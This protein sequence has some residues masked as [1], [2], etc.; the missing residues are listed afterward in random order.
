MCPDGKAYSGAGLSRHSDQILP[1][2]LPDLVLPNNS[3]GSALL[4]ATE[5]G[6][7][8]GC[9]LL[10]IWGGLRR[11]EAKR[12]L[13]S[14]CAFKKRCVETSACGMLFGILTCGVKRP[15]AKSLASTCNNA[16]AKVPD[17][18]KLMRRCL[19]IHGG[20]TAD[21]LLK[22]TQKERV[23]LEVRH[24]QHA[25]GWRTTRGG[26]VMQRER[27]VEIS[28]GVVGVVSAEECV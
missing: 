25:S 4:R 26:K 14:Y 5:E 1:H 22:S 13:V 23:L 27:Q 3:R 15:G 9:I 28:N 11:S 6:W 19:R 21:K 18:T 20:L 24:C 8:I 17:I 2:L 16:K 10:M 7:L 12:L